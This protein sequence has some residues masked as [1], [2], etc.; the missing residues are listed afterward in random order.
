M[1]IHFW[2]LLGSVSSGWGSI[3]L[4]EPLFK[5]PVLIKQLDFYLV[6]AYAEVCEISH[7]PQ[8]EI[9]SRSTRPSLASTP[10]YFSYFFLY[11]SYNRV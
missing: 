4:L 7:L 9:F 11:F 8:L 3:D 10:V 2:I 5:T 6:F 1:S